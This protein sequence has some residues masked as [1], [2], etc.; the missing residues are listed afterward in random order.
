[1]IFLSATDFFEN[2][3]DGLWQFW[4]NIQ[5]ADWTTITTQLKNW[6]VGGGMLALVIKAIPFLKN[7]NKPILNGLG[8]ISE[9]LVNAIAKIQ[10]LKSE[11]ATLKDGLKAV[12]SYLETTA[13]INLSSKVLSEEQKQ[14][15]QTAIIAL[16]SV[17]NELATHIAVEL[18][19]VADDGIITKEEA[20]T[21]A[22]HIPVIEKTLGTPI[23]GLIPK[24]DEK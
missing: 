8:E 6:I 23:A 5:N 22:E 2:I 13:N 10:E 19:K 4:V 24:G 14:M 16:L 21:I 20:L 9:A 7:S 12:V 15:F 1:M 11:N 17:Q 3:V 18:E